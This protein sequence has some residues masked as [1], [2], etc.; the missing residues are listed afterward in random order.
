[1]NNTF[2]EAT[3]DELAVL[4]N[5]VSVLENHHVASAFKLLRSKELDWTKTLTLED[6][7]DFRETVVQMV[8][9]TDMRACAPARTQPRPLR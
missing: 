6:Y 9:G 5:D 2:L 8:L 4:Y 3:K 1:M 7:K